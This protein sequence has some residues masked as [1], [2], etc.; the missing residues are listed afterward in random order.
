[1]PRAERKRDGGSVAPL[2]RDFREL[3]SQSGRAGGVLQSERRSPGVL[4]Q[5]PPQHSLFDRE[6][7]RKARRIDIIR[8]GRARQVA[9]LG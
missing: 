6:G 3:P 8:N 9:D 7:R 4:G 1:M 2:G 5:R